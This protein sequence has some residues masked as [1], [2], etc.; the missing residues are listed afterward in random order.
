[1]KVK[2]LICMVAIIML[3]ACSGSDGGTTSSSSSIPDVAG[4][5]T[6]TDITA[7]CSGLF[8]TSIV[9]IQSDENIILQAQTSGFQDASGTIDESGNIS[10]SGNFGDGTSFSCSGTIISGI[11]FASCSSC[12]VTYEE[13]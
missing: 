11:V 6:Q 8:D 1:M 7:A 13:I 12:D 5:Y 9:V 2:Q 4:S 10:V 3:V